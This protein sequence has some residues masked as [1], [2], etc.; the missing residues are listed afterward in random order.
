ME[1]SSLSYTQWQWLKECLEDNKD[2]LYGKKY[3]FASISSM[4]MYQKMV[5]IVGYQDIKKYIDAISRGEKNI[6]FSDKAVAFEMTGGS[7]GGSKLIPYTQKSFRDFQRAI[8][9]YLES[10][11]QK[12]DINPNRYVW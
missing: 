6:L 12:Y 4:G 11:F 5:P 8:L 2:S 3:H 7:T 1:Y 10:T 9:P